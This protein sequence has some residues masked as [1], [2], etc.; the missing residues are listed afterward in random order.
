MIAIMTVIA[1]NPIGMMEKQHPGFLRHHSV[2][3]NGLAAAT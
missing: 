3:R 1:E 2:S